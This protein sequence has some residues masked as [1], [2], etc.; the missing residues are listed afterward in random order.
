VDT[1]V[2]VH[3]SKLGSLLSFTRLLFPERIVA[4]KSTGVR[5]YRVHR[6]YVPWSTFEGYATLQNVARV[7]C[8]K[9]FFWDTVI[10][11]KTAGGDPFVAHRVSKRSARRFINT[12]NGWIGK[13]GT[14]GPSAA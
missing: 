4:D 5:G 2:E 9:G 7:G 8:D 10:V 11:E 13:G 3:S 1:R 14:D 12:V 6:W